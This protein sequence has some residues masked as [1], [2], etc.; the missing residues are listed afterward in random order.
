MNGARF[1]PY[2]PERLPEDEMLRRAR[3]LYAE[4][5]RRRSVRF[6]SPDPAEGAQA[7]LEKRPPD[8]GPH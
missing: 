7:I 2:R 8:F 4:L 3:E 1:I 5:D 6:F